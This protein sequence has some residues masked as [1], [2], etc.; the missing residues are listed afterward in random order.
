[1]IR[2]S[3]VGASGYSGGELM[4]LLSRHPDVELTI[5]TASQQE[6]RQ[7]GES[8]PSLRGFVDGE[9]VGPEWDELGARSDVVFL[10]LPH[11]LSMT[12]A[13]KLLAGGARVIDLGADF[14]LREV[15]LYRRWYGLE[16]QAPELLSEAVYGLPELGRDDLSEAKLVA[17]PGCYPT[18][19]ILAVL[20]V[21]ELRLEGSGVIVDAK[22]GV[23]GAGRGASAGT[24]FAEVNENVRPYNVG[25]HRHTPEMEQGLAAAGAPE[26]VLFSPHL[27][28]MTRGI[29]A[30]CYLRTAHPVAR[31][32]LEDVY[33]RR[34]A[35]WPFVRVLADRAPE[36][37]MTQGSNFCDVA[38]HAEPEQSLVV[39]MA[40]LDNLVK[41]A[42]G[43]AIQ[44]MN[45]MFGLPQEQGLWLP[46][47][48]P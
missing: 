44:C 21:L 35:A 7:V 36:T 48:F 34:Y 17:C 26:R 18:A 23:S 4:R 3:I 47:L 13:G 10:A 33:R 45:L 2:A 22:S 8:F 6:G 12:A 39:A 19:A 15:A 28:P 32:E 37:K 46:P 31:E 9:L 29:L 27:I 24:H 41:G 14:R 40:A 30:T 25:R 16:H 11:G 42:A 5:L 38:A 43:Q 1:M 20:P